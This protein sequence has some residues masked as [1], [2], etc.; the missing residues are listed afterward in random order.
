MHGNL[1]MNGN[2]VSGYTGLPT[3]LAGKGSRCNN[4][5][6]S[7]DYRHGTREHMNNHLESC[8]IQLYRA[9]LQ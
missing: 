7:L 2:R 6:T 9:V 8:D 5:G 1:N 4:L 3:G